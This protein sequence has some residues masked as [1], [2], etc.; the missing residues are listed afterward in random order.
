MKAKTFSIVTLFFIVH[1]VAAIAAPSQF[2]DYDFNFVEYGSVPCFNI[3]LSSRFNGS[4]KQTLLIPFGSRDF[5]IKTTQDEFLLNQANAT[6]TTEIAGKPHSD[7]HINYN[8]CVSNPEYRIETTILEKD[9]FAFKF[10]DVFVTPIDF[11][12]DKWKIKINTDKVKSDIALES[13]LPFSEK[14]ISVDKSMYDFKYSM[15]VG[16]N[17]KLITKTMIDKRPITTVTN[18]TLT[19]SEKPAFYVNELLKT[20]QRFWN[21]KYTQPLLITI[22]SP[23]CSLNSK[24]IEGRYFENAFII[25]I[26]DCNT[27]AGFSRSAKYSLS[28]ELFHGWLGKKIKFVDDYIPLV[29]FLEGFTDYYGLKFANESNLLTDNEFLAQYNIIIQEYYLSPLKNFS[30]NQLSN[31]H[32][33][34]M[35]IHNFIQNR[36]HLMARE[37]ANYLSGKDQSIDTIMKATHAVSIKTNKKLN[38]S[39]IKMVF[40][41]ALEV[42]DWNRFSNVIYNGKDIEFSTSLGEKFKLVNKEVEV[43]DFGFDL[44]TLLETKT[45]SGINEQSA[46]YKAGV[47]NGAQFV[48]FSL[49][50][51]N[52]LR[53]TILY[54]KEGNIQKEIRFY[55]DKRKV[56][57]PQYV[58]A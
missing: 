11:S 16:C 1:H 56:Q 49:N 46:A 55:P 34:S 40:Q 9:F 57:I 50:E 41:N 47:R 51:T 31:I 17:N 32:D 30:N 42:E 3:K 26:P 7:F 38:D 22:V 14:L 23:P 58:R 15:L 6:Y 12:K 35:N 8:Y 27:I 43:P 25:K 45:I 28:H 20:Q 48:L 13:S 4:G 21:T 2:I 29:W 44:K 36:G 37:L 19:L 24:R 39:D 18:G 52:P 33:N 54:W 5:R 53:E 10:G